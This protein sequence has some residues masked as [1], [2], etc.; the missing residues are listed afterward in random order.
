MDTDSPTVSPVPARRKRQDKDTSNR[1]Q[2]QTQFAPSTQFR[3]RRSRREQE[4]PKWSQPNRR[5]SVDETCSDY[6]SESE[7]E[8]RSECDWMSPE[9]SFMLLAEDTAATVRTGC[10]EEYGM[11]ALS[12][13]HYNQRGCGLCALEAPA[14]LCPGG[15]GK[16]CKWMTEGRV[17]G[18][19]ATDGQAPCEMRSQDNCFSDCAWVDEGG[20]ALCVDQADALTPPCFV[21][22]AQ[23]CPSNDGLCQWSAELGDCE[24]VHKRHGRDAVD[25]NEPSAIWYRSRFQDARETDACA[26]L[27]SLSTLYTQSYNEGDSEIQSTI[28]VPP[29]QKMMINKTKKIN[30]TL[31][32]YTYICS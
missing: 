16:R 32:I 14:E 22:S 27:Y 10:I 26:G 11:L 19:A 1:Y 25:A 17:E 5:R 23:T 28:K 7:C 29:S 6:Q 20:Y 13:D 3:W 9:D 31:S 18:C 21:Y 12:C 15:A 4:E 8:D 2:N 24:P 30:V